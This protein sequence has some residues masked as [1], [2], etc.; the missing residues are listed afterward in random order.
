MYED[1]DSTSTPLLS[2]RCNLLLANV[3][4]RRTPLQYKYLLGKGLLYFVQFRLCMI[5][6][7][8]YVGMNVVYV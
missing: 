8:L 7:E 5:C 1:D 4:S 2:L 6:V 3:F